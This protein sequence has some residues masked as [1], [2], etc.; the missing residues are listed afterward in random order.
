MRKILLIVLLCLAGG[1]VFAQNSNPPIGI[2]FSTPTRI[3]VGVETP[4]KVFLLNP[5]RNERVTLT[6]T[7]S[8]LV[9]EAPVE[10]SASVDITIDRGLE[11]SVGV[12]LGSL[13]LVSGSPTFD[14]QPISGVRN[15]DNTWT[16]RVTLPADGN[17]H[18]LEF[19]VIR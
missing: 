17:E 2:R 6:A 14:G 4:I 7:A 18:A 13:S 11:L 3:R 12:G 8:Y 9:G 15:N 1:A 10:T 16:F 19:R 5:Y